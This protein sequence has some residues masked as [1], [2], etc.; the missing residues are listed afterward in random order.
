MVSVVRVCETVVFLYM[1]MALLVR[2]GALEMVVM[3]VIKLEMAV[4]IVIKL[5]MVVI[6]VIKLKMV[7]ITVIKLEF[8]T[9]PY[10]I[11]TPCRKEKALL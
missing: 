6:A 9:P 5:E 10:A 11:D 7:V 2:L 1:V 4:I 3:T 8:S